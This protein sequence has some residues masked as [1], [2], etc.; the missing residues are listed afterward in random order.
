MEEM[1]AGV[2]QSIYE[3]ISRT[4]TPRRFN[5]PSRAIVPFTPPTTLSTSAG[6]GFQDSVFNFLLRNKEQLGIASVWKCKNLRADG[7][8]RL[9]DRRALALEMKVKMGWTE[10]CQTEWQFRYF[11]NTEEA[12]EFGID[13]GLAFFEEFKGQERRDWRKVAADGRE[14]GWH[15]WYGEH[16]KIVHGDREFRFDLLRFRN[17]R[18]YAF[19]EEGDGAKDLRY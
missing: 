4:Y 14:D 15:R 7:A 17:G 19:T 12:Q 5:S 16:H 6:L 10:A 9:N 11:L 13:G 1:Q 8:I 18:L 3:L 2:R